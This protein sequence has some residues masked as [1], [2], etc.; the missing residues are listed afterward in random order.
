MT[1]SVP[2]LYPQ[3]DDPPQGWS[4]AG[5]LSLHEGP[6]GR[7][8]GTAHWGGMPNV[9]WWCDRERGVAGMVATQIVPFV[10][11]FM[12]VAFSSRERVVRS[13]LLGFPLPCA[14][15]RWEGKGRVALCHMLQG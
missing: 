15:I 3:P 1:N 7:G 11:E 4:A 12:G 9:Y 6:T 5:F 10:G 13:L 14:L 2:E 8:P